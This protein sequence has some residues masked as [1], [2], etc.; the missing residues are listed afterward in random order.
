DTVRL[1]AYDIEAA[2]VLNRIIDT[3]FGVQTKDT[4]GSMNE[5]IKAV[6]Q[7]LEYMVKDIDDPEIFGL[8]ELFEIASAP[9]PSVKSIAITGRKVA[10]NCCELLT[11]SEGV[12]LRGNNTTLHS[13][14]SSLTPSL[15]RSKT[16]VLSYLRLLQSWGNHAAHSLDIHPIGI[17]ACAVIIASM[18]VVEYTIQRSESKNW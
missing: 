11:P 13:K 14:I 10:E 9:N 17:D 4:Q 5:L 8:Q 6:S 15:L 3:F 18:R 7:E 1:F 12:N 16:Y 2:A